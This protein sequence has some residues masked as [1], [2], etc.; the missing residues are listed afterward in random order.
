MVPL[1]MFQPSQ[2]HHQE[3]RR[4]IQSSTGTANLLYQYCLVYTLPEDVLVEA[5]T[6]RKDF[7]KDK[8]FSIGYVNI[9][10]FFVVCFYRLN[11]L[12]FFPFIL[13]CCIW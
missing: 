3:G 9:F 4:P 11:S 1:Y 10:G 13:F 2:G 5:E 8:P 6:C 7:I 12:L